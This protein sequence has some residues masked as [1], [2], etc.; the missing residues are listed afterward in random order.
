MDCRRELAGRN[1]RGSAHLILWGRQL[2][3]HHI[4][5]ILH[6]HPN[7]EQMPPTH[8]R[9]LL[10][11]LCPASLLLLCPFD[12]AEVLACPP[13]NKVSIAHS[14]QSTG[15]KTTAFASYGRLQPGQR[16]SVPRSLL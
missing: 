5:C 9:Q 10:D 15:W 13:K 16:A 2:H 1:D 4:H 6:H 14:S 12:P 11:G 3:S 8:A 7:T